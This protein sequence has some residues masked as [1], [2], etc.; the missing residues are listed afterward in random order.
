MLKSDHEFLEIGLVKIVKLSV[1]FILI[2]FP[3]CVKLHTIVQQNILEFSENWSR[4]GHTFLVDVIEP[5][6]TRVA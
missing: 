6:F 2:Q 3:I 4:D 1:S 5:K